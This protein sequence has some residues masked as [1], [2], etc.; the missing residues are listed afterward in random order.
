MGSFFIPAPVGRKAYRKDRKMKKIIRKITAMLAVVAMLL[1][2]IPVTAFATPNKFTSDTGT[3]SDDGDYIGSDGKYYEYTRKHCYRIIYNENTKVWE[4]VENPDRALEPAEKFRITDSNGVSNVAYCIA[5]GVPFL[6]T[7]YTAESTDTALQFQKLS[8]VAQRGILLALLYGYDGNNAVPVEGCNADDYRFATQV[9]IW[10][11]EQQLRTSTTNT[12]ISSNAWGEPADEY[13]YM[14]KN[15]PAEKCYNYILNKIVNHNKIPSFAAKLKRDADNDI[16]YLKQLVYNPSTGKYSA[17]FTD[18]NNSAVDIVSSVNGVTVSKNNNQYTFSS[19]RPFS[20]ATVRLDRKEF[21]DT[22]GC[23][24]WTSSSQALITG[25]FDPVP[26]YLALYADEAGTMQIVK[27][28]ETGKVA[29][30]KFRISG[31]GVNLTVT[32]DNSG[33]VSQTLAPGTYTVTELEVPDTIINP[34]SKTVTV[35]AGGTTNVAFSNVLKKGNVKV[36]KS[37]EDGV[38]ANIT[39]KLSGTSTS[40]KTVNMTAKTDSKGAAEFKDIPI[41][42]YRLEEVGTDVRY[43]VPEAQNV[44]VSYN[45]TVGA[46]FSNVLKKWTAEVVKKDAETDTAQADATLSGAVYGIYKDG[47]LVDTYTTDADGKFTTKEYVCGNYTMKEI[48]APAGYLLDE[49]EYQLGAEPTKFTAEKNSLN[50][51]VKDNV[52]KGKIL[53][54]K[55]SDNGETQIETPETGAEFEIYLKSAGSYEAADESVKDLVTVDEDGFAESKELPYGTYTV[56]Q[57]KGFPDVNF[58]NDFDVYIAKN[59]KTYK[60]LINNRSF[61]SYLKIVKKDAETGNTIPVSGAAYKIYDESGN[62][63]TMKYTYPVL[64]EIDTF[65]TD[66]EGYLITPEKLGYG[67]YSLVEV[68]APYGYVLNS[69]PVD[70]EITRDAAASED[71]LVIVTVSQE[72]MPQKSIITIN[73]SGSVF[74]TVKKN[75]DVYSPEYADAALKDV[76]FSIIAAED[77]IT[78]DGTVRLKKGDT[79]CEITTDAD[80]KAVSPEIYIGRYIIRETKTPAG[81]VPAEDRNVLL[82]YY[83][84]SDGINYYDYEIVN[85]RQKASVSLLKKL[86]NSEDDV[87]QVLF[88][89]YAAEEIKAEDGSVIPAGGL[90]ETANPDKTGKV[91]F[92]TDLPFGRYYVKEITAPEGYILD[93]N[94]YGFDWK[95]GDMEVTEIVINDGKVIMNIHEDVVAGDSKENKG[96]IVICSLIAIVLILNIVFAVKRKKKNRRR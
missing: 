77:I 13:S 18:T 10:E 91:S 5:A 55:H 70:F 37:S 86:E 28:S 75:D 62:P 46:A 34:A 60:F 92:T 94:E 51:N 87:T 20:K 43:V 82:T 64:T 27:T 90:I 23:I 3:S 49:T 16:N 26:F 15:R 40:G 7:G 2:I 89:L 67:K 83:N 47:V 22:T 36:T 21:T 44:T 96:I 11:Y 61:E 8:D 12:S 71:G 59:E 25:T 14:L 54:V 30:I 85:E 79:A 9:I 88:G 38:I 81:Y 50:L 41:G 39:F 52:I 31:N 74:A 45:S 63:V 73:K 69:A 35:T 17:T 68:E 80:G 66:K 33:K 24:V 84:E 58:I 4:M 57:I 6:E 42:T 48:K 56:H 19:S 1:G 93:T 32:T 95:G 76:T 29:G 78:P 65:Y 72:D 53:I